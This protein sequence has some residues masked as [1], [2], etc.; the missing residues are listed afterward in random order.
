M[1]GAGLESFLEKAARSKK[2]LP[3]ILAAEKVPV[4]KDSNGLVNP[5]AWLSV[6]N[7]IQMVKVTAEQLAVL[8]PAH[9][10]EYL[11]KAQV[12]QNALTLLQ[13]KIQKELLTIKGKYIITFHEAFPYFAKD[14]GLN[15]AAVIER[16]P[17]SEP[18]ARELVTVIK[19]IRQ[20]NAEAI[21]AEPQYPAR[22]AQLIA[23]ETGLTVSVLDPIVTGPLE[24]NAYQVIMER[25]LAALKEA[26]GGR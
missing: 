26:L 25:N 22:S 8:D 14:F 13:N 19:M 2:K 15:I 18:S 9:K 23:R 10:A 11:A 24:K 1:N 3:M 17:G 20:K 5:H 16:E 6:P 7:Y 12:Y 21:F 4:I